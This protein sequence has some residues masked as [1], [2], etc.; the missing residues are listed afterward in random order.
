MFSTCRQIDPAARLL[1]Y[2]MAGHDGALRRERTNC[3]HPLESA[4]NSYKAADYC[5]A[6]SQP[7]LSPRLDPYVRLSLADNQ[8][9]NLPSNPNG[10]SEL[11]FMLHPCWQGLNTTPHRSSS[12]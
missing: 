2:Y 4:A 3:I 7:W 9:L 6:L 10:G 5:L 11:S 8:Q 12:C 1:P